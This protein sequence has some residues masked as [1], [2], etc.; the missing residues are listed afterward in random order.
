MQVKLGKDDENYGI[1]MEFNMGEKGEEDVRNV[2]ERLHSWMPNLLD[3]DQ[4]VT[5]LNNRMIADDELIRSVR[6]PNQNGKGLLK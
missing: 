3:P 4:L 2:T 5:K 6:S 1:K